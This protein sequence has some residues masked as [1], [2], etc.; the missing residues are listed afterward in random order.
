MDHTGRRRT[1]ENTGLLQK[2]ISISTNVFA[3]WSMQSAL[4]SDIDVRIAVALATAEASSM[5]LV[6]INSRALA[7]GL[8]ADPGPVL[9]ASLA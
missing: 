7:S 8:Y 6:W 2:P 4:A 3:C 9:A 5:L 1:E